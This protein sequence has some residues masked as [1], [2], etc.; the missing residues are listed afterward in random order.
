M[1]DNANSNKNASYVWH[2][3]KC[4]KG[5]TTIHI[6]TIHGGKYFPLKL[7]FYIKYSAEHKDWIFYTPAASN[8]IHILGVGEYPNAE[9]VA[10]TKALEQVFG[11]CI[12]VA[13]II[14][15]E[16]FA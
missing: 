1:Q 15:P 8:D 11:V 10:K 2:A 16:N 14:S 7:Q 3:K 13:Q 4:K 12:G 6:L 5:E 9:I